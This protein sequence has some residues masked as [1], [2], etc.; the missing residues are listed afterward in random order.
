VNRNSGKIRVTRFSIVHDCGQII[1]P[2]GTRNQIEGS[3]IQTMSRTLLEQVE[4]DRSTITSRDWATYP[5]LTF[6]DIPE[7]E[8]ELI[9][10]PNE[11]PWGVGEAT[12]AVVPAAISNA[13]F[14]AT[15]IRL[16]SVPFK[17]EKVKA[18]LAEL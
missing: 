14:D 4:F 6:P 10:R 18:A 15:G 7:I 3:V 5:I 8:I 12:A 2:D 1:N 17:P 13:V 11:K 9:S 16:R